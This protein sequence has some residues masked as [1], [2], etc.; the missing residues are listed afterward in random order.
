MLVQEI[1]IICGI[2]APV[3]NYAIIESL[4]IFTVELIL[5]RTVFSISHLHKYY[6]E[7]EV[8]A[9]LRD[10]VMLVLDGTFYMYN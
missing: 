1:I 5:N 4:A 7:Y 8:L 3:V 6:Y 2:N 10:L 9:L